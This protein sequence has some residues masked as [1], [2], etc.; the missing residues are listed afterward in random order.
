MASSENQRT[1]TS[2]AT[3]AT[4]PGQLT[5]LLAPAM[6]IAAMFSVQLGAGLSKP[7]MALLGPIGTTALRLAWAAL[8]LSLIAR[9][10][11]TRYDGR[12][13]LAALLLGLAMSVTSILYFLSLQRIPLGLASAIE[14]L[15]PLGVAAAGMRRWYHVVWPILAAIGVGLLVHDRDGWTVDLMGAGFA[16]AAG[17]GWASYILMSKRVGRLFSGHDGLAMS[18]LFAAVITA[19][20]G[21]G[22]L[23]DTVSLDAIVE[24]AGL[25]I[26]VPLLPFVLEMSALRRM[27]TRSFGVLM[28]AE[29]AI[30]ALIGLVVLGEY[31]SLAQWLG[32]ACVTGASIGAVAEGGEAAL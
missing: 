5:S 15:G 13:W 24:M 26:L 30:G 14:F 22:E 29:P 10:R 20:L 23:R 12:Q 4:Q 8:L 11:V 28:S 1:A 7:M 17:G 21:F 32:I 6:A 9:P 25:A 18:F 3:A 16:L 2:V 19:P 31:L 27:S